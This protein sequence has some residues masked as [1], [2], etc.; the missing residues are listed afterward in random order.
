MKKALEFLKK[1]KKN[2]NTEWMHAHKDE[3]LTAKKDFEFLVQEIIVRLNQWDE[4][5]P[6]FE[7]KNCMFRF[8]RDIRFSDNK[9]PYKEN[10][11]AWFS[12]GGKKGNL[13]G[14]YLNLSPKEIYV[15]GGIWLPEAPDLKNIRRFI[16]DEG[17]ELQKILNDKKFKKTFKGLNPEHQ[18]KRPPKGFPSDHEYIDFLK[19]KSFTAS[20]PLTTED[21][22]QPNFGKVID[23]HFK[24]LKPLNHYFKRAVQT[25]G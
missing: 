1:I 25:E 4:D 11:G 21:A 20:A 5:M 23:Q 9:A 15:A 2:N 7:P 24:L 17:D 10:F 12:Y 13:P 22:L 14:Y 8:N 3:Y 18:L 19:F 16:M 6:M